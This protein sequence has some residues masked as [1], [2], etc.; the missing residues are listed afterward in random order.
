VSRRHYHGLRRDV[1]DERDYRARRVWSYLSA[2]RAPAEVHLAAD[3]HHMPRIEDQGQAG[4]CGPHAGTSALEYVSIR[5]GHPVVELS[6]LE[7]Y[8]LTR[9]V[10]AGGRAEDDTGVQNRD[11]MKALAK[12]GVCSEATWPYDLAQLATPP[13]TQALN[14]GT[15]H[16]ITEYMR[17]ESLSA[18]RASLAA[19]WPVVMGF[20]CPESF[21]DHA[22]EL[23]GVVAMP[24]PG[25]RIIGAHDVLICG[26]SDSAQAFDFEN[27]YGRGWGRD[28]FGALPYGYVKRGLTIDPW[29]IRAATGA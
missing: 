24:E 25:E 7:L 15:V 2:L 19:G 16:R 14:E 23:T 21:E 9:V 5:L 10:I 26:Y 18:L 8:Y 17:C 13:S 28:G 1:P 3:C 22:T 11:L 4:T 6:P 29:T 20:S 27:S 12:Y